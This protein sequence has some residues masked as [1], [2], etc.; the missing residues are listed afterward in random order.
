LEVEALFDGV[1]F[2]ESLTRARFEELNGPLQEDPRPGEE[3][4][5]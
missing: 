1:D 4:D 3:R 5:G 2:S